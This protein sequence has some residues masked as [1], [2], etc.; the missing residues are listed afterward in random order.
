MSH[1]WRQ[2]GARGGFTLIELMVAVVIFA[3]LAALGYASL[4]KTIRFHEITDDNLKKLHDLQTAVRLLGQDFQQLAPRPV[5]DPLGG[6]NQPA[7]AADARSAYAVLMTRG[8]W[9]NNAGIQRPS[10]QR[11]GY[12]VDNGILRRDSWTV[13]DATPAN[14]PVRREIIRGVKRFEIRYMD[15]SHQWITQWPP[16]GMPPPLNE[17]TRPIAV[18]VTLEL[19]DWGVISRVFEIPA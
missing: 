10:L 6:P 3:I 4:S 12:L 14:E 11:V 9:T 1:R 16:P 18:E 8:G 13:L 2:S 19:E 7:L 17:R 5:R 15:I